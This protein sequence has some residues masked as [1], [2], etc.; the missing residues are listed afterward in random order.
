[1]KLELH[2]IFMFTML[3]MY[4]KL[5]YTV[6]FLVVVEEKKDISRPVYVAY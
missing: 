2:L 4:R 3:K 1:M 5:H 6:L